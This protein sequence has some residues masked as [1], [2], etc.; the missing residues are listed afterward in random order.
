[1]DNWIDIETEMPPFNKV[2]MA[3]HKKDGLVHLGNVNK[4]SNGPCWAIRRPFK[5]IDIV[6]PYEQETE[7]KY[8]LS[9]WQKL[10]G[11]GDYE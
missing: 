11:D 10:P 5:N 7:L 8:H 1:M 3:V 9:H 4:D 2:R 6:I